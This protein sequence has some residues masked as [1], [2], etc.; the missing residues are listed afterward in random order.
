MP[1]KK[2][3]N[4]KEYLELHHADFTPDKIE[5]ILSFAAPKLTE[6]SS[7]HFCRKAT[8]LIADGSYS[9]L[10]KL[11]ISREQAIKGQRRSKLLNPHDYEPC[12]PFEIPALMTYRW[13]TIVRNVFNDIAKG[14]AL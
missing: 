11:I 8:R 4:F 2:A 14:L 1:K 12:K 9:D 13:S 5:E 10:E 6:D 3:T 7:I